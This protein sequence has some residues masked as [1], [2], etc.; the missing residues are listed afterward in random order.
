[1]AS[2][3][4]IGTFRGAALYVGA[5][6][7]PAALT[8]MFFLVAVGLGA[9]AV[10]VVGGYYAADLTGPSSVVAIAAGAAM[11]GSVLWPTTGG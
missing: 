10:S 9:P 3:A 6:V 8:S 7:G 1:M 11:Y 4:G 2:E 5:I